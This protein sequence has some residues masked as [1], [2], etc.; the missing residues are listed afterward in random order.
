MKKNAS[1]FECPNAIDMDEPVA[2]TNDPGGY[3]YATM[4]DRE[5]N[6]HESPWQLFLQALKASGLVKPAGMNYMVWASQMYDRTRG[7]FEG[8]SDVIDIQ[9]VRCKPA[10]LSQDERS[11]D[12]LYSATMEHGYCDE[13]DFS[14]SLVAVDY[15]DP[16]SIIL[17]AEAETVPEMEETERTVFVGCDVCQPKEDVAPAASFSRPQ[18]PSKASSWDAVMANV[19][20]SKLDTMWRT[21][22]A[23]ARH[24]EYKDRQTRRQ[25]FERRNQFNRAMER[26]DVALGRAPET[27]YKLPAHYRQS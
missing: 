22:L 17:A 13:A 4:L 7:A 1:I 2:I 10:Y 3:S 25:G 11:N 8:T 5:Q 15:N 6:K 16:L 9:T 14:S 21:F 12:N 19:K 26:A 23:L 27:W 18:F 20:V 24:D